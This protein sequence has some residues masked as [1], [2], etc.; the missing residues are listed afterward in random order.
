M[1]ERRLYILIGMPGAGKSTWAR[2]QPEQVVSTD[3]IRLELTGDERN[4]ERNAWVFRTFYTRVGRALS[5]GV[6]ADSTGLDA[7]TREHLIGIGR[8]AGARVIACVWDDVAACY[9]RNARRE[10]PIPL[11]VMRRMERKLEASLD[12]L[13]WEDYDEIRRLTRA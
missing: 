9:D 1:T 13:A 3:A 7:P 11:D 12:A 6:I 5:G 4:M 10:R 8:A 2:A